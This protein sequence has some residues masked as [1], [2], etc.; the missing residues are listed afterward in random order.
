M[1]AR[2]AAALLLSCSAAQKPPSQQAGESCSPSAALRSEHARASCLAKA[3]ST[4]GTCHASRFAGRCGVIAAVTDRAG[5]APVIVQVPA[6]GGS[7]AAP[8]ATFGLE[9][10]FEIASNT[11]VLTAIAF[12]CLVARG[13]LRLNDTLAELL[14][15][16]VHFANASVG[17]I[18]MDELLS[19]TSGLARL[20]SNLHGT[21]QNQFTNYTAADLYS[22]LSSV[23]DL[24]TRGSFLYSNLA[25]GLL[26]HLMELKTGRGFEELVTSEVLAPLGMGDTKITLTPAAWRSQVAPGL[27]SKGQRAERNTPC[28]SCDT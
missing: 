26:G 25:F 9:T 4:T 11:K 1:A 27:D 2:M 14:P 10:L 16:T 22:Y 21:P 8:T 19:H 17:S 15:P 12:H 6:G 18:R 13:E 23:S 28:K 24:P 7:P 3:W 20:P 5:G